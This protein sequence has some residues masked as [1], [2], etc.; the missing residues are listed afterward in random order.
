MLLV[1]ELQ[2]HVHIVLQIR[3][4]AEELV[5]DEEELPITTKDD[6]KIHG[7][8]IRSMRHIVWKYD[9]FLNINEEDGCFSLKVLIP[10]PSEK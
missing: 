8:G 2:K 9:G 10:I 6:K 1:P 3:P 4:M 5:Y 7:F